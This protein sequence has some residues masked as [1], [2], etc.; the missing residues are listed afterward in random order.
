MM[1][2]IVE[3]SVEHKTPNGLKVQRLED[4]GEIELI[5]LSGEEDPNYADWKE[6]IETRHYL[7]SSK[8]FGQQIKYL[9]KSLRYGWIGALA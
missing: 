4:L 2:I 5:L 9:V 1:P 3:D 7:H 6:M 8:L